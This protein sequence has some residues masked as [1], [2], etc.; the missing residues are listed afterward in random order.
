MEKKSANVA[1]MV[2]GRVLLNPTTAGTAYNQR[3]TNVASV[4][5]SPTA[6]HSSYPEKGFPPNSGTTSRQG[7]VNPAFVGSTSGIRSESTPSVQ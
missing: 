5:F 3:P 1:K 2:D 7:I 6:G 4:S